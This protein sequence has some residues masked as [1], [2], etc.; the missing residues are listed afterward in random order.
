MPPGPITSRGGRILRGIS[1]EE[2][3]LE[4]RTADAA[5]VARSR[6]P[7][8]GFV[9]VPT[10]PFPNPVKSPLNPSLETPEEKKNVNHLKKYNDKTNHLRRF[11]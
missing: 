11:V 10:N 2:V 5:P 1:L 6:T 8:A 7:T 4:S 9:T 3:R